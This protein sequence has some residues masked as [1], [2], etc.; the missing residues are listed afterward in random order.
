[1]KLNN[2][3]KSFFLSFT[4]IL[5]SLISFSI[6]AQY[7]YA[8]KDYSPSYTLSPGSSNNILYSWYI[9]SGNNSTLTSISFQLTGTFS[10]TDIK[11]N[12]LKL[13]QNSNG[14]S[15]YS[16]KSKLLYVTSVPG[17]GT[18]VTF[19]GLNFTK[20]LNSNDRFFITVD[21][22]PTATLGNNITINNFNT[23][24]PSGTSKYISDPNTGSN[25]TINSIS[26][27]NFNNN[28]VSSGPMAI[29]SQ[30]NEL[31]KAYS[32]ISNS[33]NLV[34]Q[35][36]VFS[37]TGTYA[38]SDVTVF[39]LWG[40][41]GNYSS[42]PVLLATAS[43]IASGSKILFNSSS[44]GTNTIN[45]AYNNT[46]IYLSVT[47]DI[48]STLSTNSGVT[49]GIKSNPMSNVSFV[50]VNGSNN[51]PGYTRSITSPAIQVVTPFSPNGNIGQ[52][53]Q[54]NLIYS[55]KIRSNNSNIPLSKIR[56]LTQGT[57]NATDVTQFTLY[58]NQNSNF[59]PSASDIVSTATASGLGQYLTFDVSDQY[60][61]Q[62][63]D[64]YFYLAADVSTNATVNRTV[65]I[66]SITN[67]DLTISSG[68]I[69]GTLL[70][71]GI[72][73]IKSPTVKVTQIPLSTTALSPGASY[74][75]VYAF[76]VEVGD[77]PV[78]NLKNV[79]FNTSGTFV[80]GDIDGFYLYYNYT[81]NPKD[82]DYYVNGNYN[83]TGPGSNLTFG[84]YNVNYNAN[85]IVYYFLY[86]NMS[87]NAA[88][89]NTLRVNPTIIDFDPN[90]TEIITT[91]QSILYPIIIPTLKISSANIAPQAG[92]I[93]VGQSYF[94]IYKFGYTVTGAPA[95]IQDVYLSISGTFLSSDI[96]Y[97]SFVR[98]NDEI[99][100]PN[101]NSNYTYSNFYSYNST[102]SGELFNFG[103]YD[104]L[105]VG[106]GYIYVVV[107]LNSNSTINNTLSVNPINGTDIS[108]PNATVLGSTSMGS[109]FT[110]LS[111]SFI[112]YNLPDNFPKYLNLNTYEQKPIFSFAIKNSSIVGGNL[113]YINL[114][115]SGV[116]NSNEF[117]YLYIYETA[118]P[119]PPT[120]L[121]N[122]IANF[123][124]GNSN[125]QTFSLNLNNNRAVF[126]PGQTKY[127]HLYIWT[128]YQTPIVGDYVAV[129]GVELLSNTPTTT[130]TNNIMPGNAKIFQ[131]VLTVNSVNTVLGSILSPSSSA[132]IYKLAITSNSNNNNNLNQAVFTILGNLSPSDINYFGLEYYDFGYPDNNRN[133][134]TTRNFGNGVLSFTGFNI[135][136]TNKNLYLVAYLNNTTANGVTLSVNKPNLTDFKF[137]T[138]VVSG[139]TS[140]GSLFTI[141][142]PVLTVS[143]LPLAPGYLF[144][145]SGYIPIGGFKIESNGAARIYNFSL[146]ASG[147]YTN[148]DINYI[149]VVRSPSASFDYNNYNY[150]NDYS[151]NSNGTGTGDV[152][153]FYL[154][155][156]FNSGTSYYHILAYNVLNTAT[157]GK[158]IKLNIGSFS[159]SN[160]S[161]GIVSNNLFI[162][163]TY[164]V[165]S[166]VISVANVPIAA[167]TVGKSTSD[168]L[169]YALE[170]NT[171]APINL[172]N[173]KFNMNG[174]FSSNDVNYYKLF[175][176]QS[177]NFGFNPNTA[178]NIYNWNGTIGSGESF[179]VSNAG[180]QILPGKSYIYISCNIG[181]NAINGRTLFVDP[182]SISGNM[183]SYSITGGLLSAGSVFTIASPII[184]VAS[185]PIVGNTLY[186]GQNNQLVHSFGI[187]ISGAT[188]TLSYFYIYNMKGNYSGS[189]FKS[190]NAFEYYLSSSPTFDQNA[191]KIAETQAS[192][193]NNENIY[194]YP[195]AQLPIGISYVHVVAN[196]S[197]YASGGKTIQFSQIG[198]NIYFG[199]SN[200]SGSI[201]EGNLF[202]IVANQSI[203]GLNNQSLM[204]G[205]TGNFGNV[206]ATSGLDVILSSSNQ[207]ILSINGINYVALAG[208]IVTV[209]GSQ[210]G[211]ANVVAAATVYAVITINP[212]MQSI[213]GFT[214]ISNKIYGNAP[215][216]ISVAT[217]TS[218]LPVSYISSGPISLVGNT[219]SILGAGNASIT[220]I[221]AGNSNYSAA[222]PVIQTFNISKATQTITGF[223]AIPNKT[224]GDAPISLGGTS[225]AGLPVNYNAIGNVDILGTTATIVGT[226][227]VTI[228]ANQ[229]GNANYFPAPSVSQTF[230]IAK[231]NPTLVFNANSIVGLG[232]TALAASTN[233]TGVLTYNITGGTAQASSSINGNILSTTGVGTL[234]ITASLASNANF[235]ATSLGIVL[236]VT[237]QL[238]PTIVY[239]GQTKTY[240]DAPF[241]MTVT[242]TNST[243]LITYSVQS[244]TAAQINPTSG[245]VTILGAGT[246][247]FLAQISSDINYSPGTA[248]TTLT[249]NK[250]TP[251]LTITSPISGNVFETITLSSAS[252]S[253]NNIS[254]TV[255]T[256]P[257]SAIVNVNNTLSLLE[258]G[259]VTITASQIGS[260]NFNPANLSTVV[261]IN[262]LNQTIT[263]FAPVGTKTYTDQPFDVSATV[264]SGLPINFS[265]TGAAVLLGNSTIS[266]NNVGVVTVTA[267]QAGNNYYNAANNLNLIFTVNKADQIIN[268]FAPITDRVY[269]GPSVVTLN[270]VATSTLAVLYSVSGPALV[271]GNLLSIT[272]IGPIIVTA[273]QLGNNFYNAA[274]IVNQ[275]FNSLKIPQVIGGFNPISTTSIG[276][277]SFLLNA[278]ATSG[279]PV[280]FAVSGNA[281]LTGGNTVSITGAGVITITAL[282]VG[283]SNYQAAT[284]VIRYVTVTKAFQ[285]LSVTSLPD[286]TLTGTNNLIPL[287]GVVSSGLPI[288]YVASGPATVIGS[289]LSITGP[290]V[291]SI[292]ASQPG[293]ENYE[294]SNTVTFS[295]NVVQLNTSI[296]LSSG[297]DDV[298]YLLFPNPASGIIKIIGNNISMIS[299]SNIAGKVV[300]ESGYYENGYDLTNLPKGI[301][302]V[303]L[304]VNGQK[305]VKKLILN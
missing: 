76:K 121:N 186:A 233:S 234:N 181:N 221:Q 225:S 191:V 258:V 265:V 106:S 143:S 216:T 118:T 120:A 105:P 58:R 130:I 56:F 164:T 74:Q 229:I 223:S 210:P 15:L 249:I 28:G 220:A 173:L 189:D 285:T 237:S 117:Y 2:Y 22:E 252:L 71:G 188:A 90:V 280:T 126:A 157:D 54:N 60:Y 264:T 291:V 98:S 247:T 48:N 88:Q 288:T 184:N 298:D 139:T 290:G 86:A 104:K 61:Y 45:L 206:F 158:T 50:G 301:Y 96:S 46:L 253:P 219:V 70:S 269:Y 3:P 14:I 107:N 296:S 169:I 156:D 131:N 95:Y 108:F 37:T 112:A 47:A 270:G 7:V 293:N 35:A 175:H 26:S 281:I 99:Y 92:G 102:G 64:Y 78:S 114:S 127:Y 142:V 261:S 133:M 282:Q 256:G 201:N 62:N 241:A 152:F 162:G 218:G 226:G 215:F 42:N 18:F 89:G 214:P 66:A 183:F 109:V 147:T 251:T 119:F 300:F 13:W 244:G 8:Y 254:Y 197:P 103:V 238:V 250:F 17:S 167:S 145:G 243:G 224:F 231:A 305:L 140:F 172:N 11:P 276:G 159:G 194:V 163:Q 289:N 94:P 82:L 53:I 125:N 153:N 204:Y 144:K 9:S 24:V 209:T 196:L 174:A 273:Y 213:I 67:N 259:T 257:G 44:V 154:N 292:T 97:F 239:N 75:P 29:G 198:S 242:T 19:A 217:A 43:G 40:R 85:D 69:T 155:N 77:F 271:S 59:S 165:L 137:N 245:L 236:T 10:P 63:T 116:F 23:I 302:F 4:I 303:Q 93:P 180:Y 30:N 177:P 202:T 283:N 138:T 55:V 128:Y 146:T 149:S 205:A 49:V 211:N 248:I 263:G 1:M 91:S 232:A 36:G 5:L 122:E 185:N 6:K 295:F 287:V 200:K 286:F 262:K 141:G 275:S 113:D 134:I 20:P 255:I 266:I 68:S 227:N 199:N 203:L 161:S 192:S 150:I 267:M 72:Q 208:G 294:A 279:L 115:L 297:I 228:T 187:T 81:G 123:Y 160:F 83:I 299:I 193:G 80:S 21:I 222:I 195:Y 284:P 111:S 171:N 31:F 240:L 151:V 33:T 136:M 32:Y 135:N 87:S 190:N 182:V 129:T 212:A 79:I 132:I 39:K 124:N 34:F 51:V 260:N 170:I 25:L 73:T 268:G 304:T 65:S 207:N 277:P 27:V 246:V 16:N 100:N 272:G 274:P 148:S 110:I 38:V 176:S 235:N 52:G 41:E 12:S 166:P 278:T 178:N 84:G 101:S 179:A 57:F 230:T 168:F